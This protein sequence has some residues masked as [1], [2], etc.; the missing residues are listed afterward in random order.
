MPEAQ[1]VVR[2]DADDLARRR[3]LDR[4]CRC[5]HACAARGKFLL[6]LAGGST[7]EQAYLQLA[8]PERRGRIDWEK[9]HVF[10]GDDRF[11]PPDD[12]RSNLAMA[13]RTLLT[14]VPIPYG[15]VQAI[16]TQRLPLPRKRRTLISKSSPA[17]SASVKNHRRQNSISSSWA[18][19]TMGTPHLCSRA[20]PRC[21]S[22]IAGSRPH[23]RRQRRRRSIAS[24]P[25]FPSSMRLAK[26]YS[27]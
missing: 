2:K 23:P 15:N 5:P 17:S 22:R 4:G 8:S 21:W 7:P 13:A 1:I 11:V 18:S 3:G 16:S 6:A 26:L 12:P 20:T 19:E 10:L 14:R 9:F 25:L 27:L 24:P